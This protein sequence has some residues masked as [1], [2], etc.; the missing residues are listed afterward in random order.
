MVKA[1]SK[2]VAKIVT[3]TEKAACSHVTE[4]TRTLN[5]CNENPTVPPR[6]A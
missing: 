5:Y 3:G 2:F 1:I 4:V 6:E